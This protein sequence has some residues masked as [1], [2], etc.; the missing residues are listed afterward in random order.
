MKDLHRDYGYER[1]VYHSII[2]F[3]VFSLSL[4]TMGFSVRWLSVGSERTPAIA[5]LGVSVLFAVLA[6]LAI[7]RAVGSFYSE[8]ELSSEFYEELHH[9]T[10]QYRY[11]GSDPVDST[12]LEEELRE[13]DVSER[14][15]DWQEAS[16]EDDPFDRDISTADWESKAIEFFR[17]IERVSEKHQG[18]D[19]GYRRAMDQMKAQFLRLV[20]PMGISII[21]PSPGGIYDPREHEISSETG[22]RNLPPWTIVFCEEAGYR[23]NG[24]VRSRAKV[25]ISRR[26]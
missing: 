24:R 10:D 12:G 23:V 1:L 22:D 25:T 16:V 11:R 17:T 3:S 7:I 9:R 4:T 15:L 8:P 18:S 19:T 26:G 6:L 20:V 21:E 5:L 13:S 14:G 2:M